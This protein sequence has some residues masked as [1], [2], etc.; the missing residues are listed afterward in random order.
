[1]LFNSLQFLLFFVVVTILYFSLRFQLRWALLLAASCYFYMVFQPAYI[2]ILFLTIV[3]DYI[4]GLWIERSEG[5][6]RKWLLILS[7]ISNIGI[8]AFFKYLGFFTENIALLFDALSMPDLADRITNGTNRIFVGVLKLF[9]ES[10]IDSFKDNMSILPIGLSFHTFQAMSYTIEVYRGNQ[11]AERHFGIYALYVMF[12]PQL[13]AGPIERPQNVL[14]QFHKPHAY[15]FEEVKAGL[16]Q[17][18]F[19][20]FKKCVIADRLVLFLDPAFNHPEGYNGLSLLM[21]TFFFT[22]QIY[23]DFSAYS[24][25]AIGAA[26]VMGFKLMENFH[27]PYFAHSISEFWR[28]WHISLSTWFR[29]YLYIPLGGN[30]KGPARTY[31]NR[32]IVF[33]TSGLWHGANWTY[34]IWGALHGL[35]IVLDIALDKRKAQKGKAEKTTTQLGG[36]GLPRRVFGVLFTFVLVM[37]TWV[38]FRAVSVSDA[39]LIL[40]R[41]VTLS[42]SDPL[43]SALNPTEL[44]FSFGLIA[45][46]FWKEWYY[47]IIPTRSTVRFAVLF[48]LLAFTTY[49]FGVFT[50]N[51]FIYFQF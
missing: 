50:S 7:L 45:F 3:I 49:L 31:L 41:I 25:I 11:K 4:A 17:M 20:F 15:D 27:T 8:L 30:R 32:F 6:T 13:V 12:Y 42:P 33:M 47:F 19:G 1:M 9:G 2:L 24:D 35:Y 22:I 43:Q 23:C 29:D 40:G 21:A 38:F 44:W 18:A 14:H 36:V 46:M 34:V 48:G 51:Q 5:K 26:R 16:M 39:L 10:G 28:R 37:L